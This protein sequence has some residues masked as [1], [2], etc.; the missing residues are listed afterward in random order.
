M[1]DTQ[2]TIDAPQSAQECRDFV[3][4]FARVNIETLRSEM[5]ASLAEAAMAAH[6]VDPDWEDPALLAESGLKDSPIDELVRT[7]KHYLHIDIAMSP[8]GAEA[9]RLF[10]QMTGLSAKQLKSL[11]PA[12]CAKRRVDRG[13]VSTEVQRLNHWL[14]WVRRDGF[15]PTL[16]IKHQKS[17]ALH[18]R[19]QNITGAIGALGASIAF[20]DAI[21]SKNPKAIVDTLGTEPP[22]WTEGQSPADL[23]LWRKANSAPLSTILLHNG[24]A[25]VFAS[26]KDV[27]IFMPLNKPFESAADAQKRFNAVRNNAEARKQ[28][29]HEFAV[30]EVKTA[31]DISNLHERLGLASRETQTELRT[32]RFLMMAL[33]TKELLEGGIQRRTMNNRDLKRFSHMFNLHHCWGW[34][35]GR[36]RH[37]QH[38]EF[39]CQK[40]E[41]WCGI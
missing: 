17:I 41:T 33:L 9:T 15:D 16:F 8:S 2:E 39:F 35:G 24:R 3:E 12:L 21:R 27:N 31:T 11:F 32:D 25:I 20:L 37:P 22:P 4:A 14:D 28:V 30:G 10:L 23:F 18:G 38:W 6:K 1:V 7:G 34:D 29:L 26:S 19:T 13:S 5:S 36:E 40:I